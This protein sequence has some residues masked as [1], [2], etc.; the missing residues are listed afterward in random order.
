MASARGA[1]LTGTHEFLRYG[2]IRTP[3]PSFKDFPG[4]LGPARFRKRNSKTSA[5]LLS[6][7]RAR[8]N[9]FPNTGHPQT[10]NSTVLIVKNTWILVGRPVMQG[11]LQQQRFAVHRARRSRRHARRRDPITHVLEQKGFENQHYNSPCWV[12]PDPGAR[13]KIIADVVCQTR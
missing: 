2:R 9:R 6:G 10:S 7:S 11:S 5:R 1:Q 12:F 3:P 4:P 13:S 8:R